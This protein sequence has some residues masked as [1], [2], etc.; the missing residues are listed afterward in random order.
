V[1][2]L[3]VR[4]VIKYFHLKGMTPQEIFCDYKETLW[5]SAP[6]YCTVE[7]WRAEFKRGRSS[8][9]EL[10]R[11]GRPAT[12]VD[13][14]T[15]ERV[16]KL[17]TNDRRLDSFFYC[18]VCWHLCWQCTFDLDGE[19]V[20]EE[21]ICMM[22]AADVIGRSWANRVDASISLLHLFNENPNGFISRFLTVDET[23]IHDFDPE[24][25][26]QLMPWK[27]ASC[28]PTRKFRV[29]ASACKVMV[30]VFWDAVGI[31][32]IDYLEHAVLSQEPTMLI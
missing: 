12:S 24:S 30:T 4:A 5:E 3:K 29:V 25:K 11:C 6:A 28:P 22:G 17:V 15:V 9:D 20:D 32:L 21:G 18:F 2:K 7:K 14:E 31:V 16:N 27:H 19:F 1:E 26:V 23:W 8:C 13:E 10:H